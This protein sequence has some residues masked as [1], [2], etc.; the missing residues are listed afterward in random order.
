M[1]FSEISLISLISEI[2]INH[3][4]VTLT[5]FTEQTW[6]DQPVH[7]GTARTG[8][9]Y[10]GTVSWLCHSL[11]T[12]QTSVCEGVCVCVKSSFTTH[13]FKSALLLLVHHH[14]F[15]IRPVILMADLCVMSVPGPVLCQLWCE[16]APG[17]CS[18]VLLWGQG[19]SLPLVPLQHPMAPQGAPC[20]LQWWALPAS[21]ALSEGCLYR[22]GVG[23]LSTERP[24]WWCLHQEW[25]YGYH[26]ISKFLVKS[27]YPGTTHHISWLCCVV[28]WI[29]SHHF[30]R[31]P[32]STVICICIALAQTSFLLKMTTVP[33]RGH[34]WPAF[35]Q[36]GPWKGL[37][38]VSSVSS[39]HRSKWLQMP[40]PPNCLH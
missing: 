12:L 3:G 28:T 17:L 37:I 2:S 29:D 20:S 40:L 32:S 1:S 16:G 13:C 24:L 36:W 11:W 15:Q 18:Q 5:C 4:Y 33:K 9:V 26:W 19:L 25:I 31:S 22:G 39:V 35:V 6:W 23:L 14:N 21:S 30:A 8:C 38:G 34:R 7:Q 10:T 27:S